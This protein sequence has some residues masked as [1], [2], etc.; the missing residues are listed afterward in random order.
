MT[1]YISYI[2]F[3]KPF[4]WW[5]RGILIILVFLSKIVIGQQSSIDTVPNIVS[6]DTLTIGAIKNQA[7]KIHIQEGTLVVDLSKKTKFYKA[8]EEVKVAVAK[9]KKNKKTKL[10]QK[11]LPIQIAVNSLPKP[12]GVILCSLPQQNSGVKCGRFSQSLA[13][14]TAFKQKDCAMVI[15]C[16][17]LV[18]YTES[19]NTIPKTIQ[20]RINSFTLNCNYSRPPPSVIPIG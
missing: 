5:F 19:E 15:Q 8:A 17:P 4:Y 18:A 16:N 9:P 10:K 13:I 3:E 12:Q 2:N 1:T 11:T 6:Q 14:V 7:V 20:E